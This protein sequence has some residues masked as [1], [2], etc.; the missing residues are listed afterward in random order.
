MLSV[1][2]WAVASVLASCCSRIVEGCCHLARQR[3]QGDRLITVEVDG[4]EVLKA[5]S[6]GPKPADAGTEGAD[7]AQDCQTGDCTGANDGPSASAASQAAERAQP[8]Q[9]VNALAYKV[10]RI[11][12]SRFKF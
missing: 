8:V 5:A 11:D 10:L 7:P 4:E 9:K 1:E 3:V 2:V 12:R 6:S